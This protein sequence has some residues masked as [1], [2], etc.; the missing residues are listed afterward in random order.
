VPI[1]K[2][3]VFAVLLLITSCIADRGLSK[4]Y[5]D[6]S[7]QDGCNP[8]NIGHRLGGDFEIFPDNSAQGMR[9]ISGMQKS[10][11]FKH[12]ELDV[13]QAL[14]AIVLLHDSVYR[15]TPVIKLRKSELPDNTLDITE[16]VEQFSQMSIIKPVIIDLKY[17]PKN[18]SWVKVK[19]VAESIKNQH[20]VAVWFITSK[21]QVSNMEG[22]CSVMNG[23]FDIMLYGRGGKLC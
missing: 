7:A 12:W 11:C 14:D 9:G 4:R 20:Q 22:I 15:G 21:H 10:T 3:L 18:N 23:E 1:F 2:Y 17:M 13:N 6:Y 5:F 19:Q 16:F 8:P